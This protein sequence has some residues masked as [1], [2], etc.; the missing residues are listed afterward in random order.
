MQPAQLSHRWEVLLAWKNTAALTVEDFFLKGMLSAWVWSV[1]TAR[2]WSRPMQKTCRNREIKG[3]FNW[4]FGFIF[5]FPIV[6]LFLKAPRMVVREGM[7]EV[8]L[9][10]D[11]EL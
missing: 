3:G 8:F 1:T 10:I 4:T 7:H 2:K 11:T 9:M 6:S 5:L